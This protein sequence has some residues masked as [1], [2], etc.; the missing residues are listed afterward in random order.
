L[1]KAQPRDASATPEPVAP[2]VPPETPVEPSATEKPSHDAG[3]AVSGASSSVSVNATPWADVLIDGRPAGTTPL[4]KVK[5]RPGPH[6]LI[7]RCPPL[8]REEVLKLDFPPGQA[9]RVV[10]DLSA[11][12]ARTFL[13]GVHEA[14]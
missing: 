14:R 10:V 6:T 12:P 1:P 13:D 9:A 11:S 4:R 5:L 7:L 2:S 3:G 8:G